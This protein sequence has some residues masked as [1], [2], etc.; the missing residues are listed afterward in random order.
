MFVLTGPTAAGKTSLSIDL[1]L[2]WGGEIISADSMQVYRGMDIGT[3]KPSMD[4]RRGVPHH[5]IDIL[6][7]DEPYSVAEFQRLAGEAIQSIAL[8]GLIPM[9]VGGTALYIRA[10]VDD[11]YFPDA[12]ADA[13]LRESLA[14]QADR[15]GTAALHRML[16]EMDPSSAARIHPND[17][18]RLIRAIEV[19]RVTGVRLSEFP[20]TGRPFSEA[21]MACLD[22]PREE[23]YGRIDARVDE[24]IRR[25]LIEEVESLHRMGYDERFFS[26]NSLGYREIGDYLRGRA[27]IEDAVRLIK[28]N[29]RRFSKRQL[30]W[31]R[32]D[33]RIIWIRAGH[34]RPKS[35]VLEDI[36]RLA[37]GKWSPA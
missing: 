25:G 19:C 32:R 3:A 14:L 36:S 26:M 33:P 23:L 8:R 13:D 6:D 31:F 28:R 20:R 34:D 12:P 37:E 11:Y 5:L 18:K 9:V 15:E 22:I 27:T 30:T 7:P 10:L 16:G 29:T 4:E 17:L 2:A 24:Q 1:A 35:C 21:F